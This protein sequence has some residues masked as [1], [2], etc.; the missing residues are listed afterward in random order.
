MLWVG[1]GGKGKCQS[2]VSPCAGGGGGGD[3]KT[4]TK[5]Q[6]PARRGHP[7]PLGGEGGEEKGLRLALARRSGV[8][9][10]WKVRFAG[11]GHPQEAKTR[12]GLG[13]EGEAGRRSGG[14]APGH[15]QGRPR[16]R[17][18]AKGRVCC[19][20]QDSS[21]K[22]QQGGGQGP[23]GRLQITR[24]RGATRPLRLNSTQTA[25]GRFF[26]L[27]RQKAV[28][29]KGQEGD[30]PTKEGGERETGHVRIVWRW[31]GQGPLAPGTGHERDRWFGGMGRCRTKG[32]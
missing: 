23:K 6:P 11:F 1:A 16:L 13:G 8:R 31:P 2:R 15:G 17:R 28:H 10:L 24:E 27:G 3:P 26:G 9:A 4:T 22:G 19:A 18:A 21:R 7:S 30:E 25:P 14:R 20:R 29:L 5:R 32:D 12:G